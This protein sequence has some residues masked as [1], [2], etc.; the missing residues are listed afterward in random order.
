VAKLRTAEVRDGTIILRNQEGRSVF[1][2]VRVSGTDMMRDFTSA[3]AARFV[4][5]IRALK[6]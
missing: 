6:R 3:D 1:T 4:N 5:A 2:N